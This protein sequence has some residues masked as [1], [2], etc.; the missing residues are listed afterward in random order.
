MKLYIVK[1]KIN[2]ILHMKKR[3][4]TENERWRI[5]GFLDSNPNYSECAKMY[6]ISKST[7]MRIAKKFAE[8]ARIY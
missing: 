4:L 5:V 3:E 8:T 6:G 7:V 1:T 2:L